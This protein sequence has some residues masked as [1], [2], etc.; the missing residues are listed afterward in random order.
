[1][2]SAA[3]IVLAPRWSEGFVAATSSTAA[4]KNLDLLGPQTATAASQDTGARLKYVRIYAV[5]TDVAVAF[6][7][8]PGHADDVLFP[9]SGNAGT[10]AVTFCVPVFASTYQDFV[11]PGDYNW[12]GYVTASATGVIVVYISSRP[13]S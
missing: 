11:V 4:T 7:D 3:D 1:M 8:T 5:T 6:A 12:L 2:A 13:F 9:A 10:N